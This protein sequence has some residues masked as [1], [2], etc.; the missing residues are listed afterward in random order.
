[1]RVRVISQSNKSAEYES[2]VYTVSGG[3][4]VVCDQDY[5][6]GGAEAFGDLCI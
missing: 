4:T 1:M 3:S 6:Y 5:G 2:E